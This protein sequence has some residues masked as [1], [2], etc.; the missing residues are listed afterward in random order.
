[1]S[2]LASRVV[3]MSQAVD[4]CVVFWHGRAFRIGRLFVFNRSAFE[5]EDVETFVHYQLEFSRVISQCLWNLLATCTLSLAIVVFDVVTG[6]DTYMALPLR[7]FIVLVSLFPAVSYL[8]LPVDTVVYRDNLGTIVTLRS[9]HLQ[10]RCIG[11]LL[12][13]ARVG[14]VASYQR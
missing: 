9:F 6:S 14:R 10:R 11:R 5:I 13:S 2:A 4:G 3:S 1:M 7:S 12:K 8:V